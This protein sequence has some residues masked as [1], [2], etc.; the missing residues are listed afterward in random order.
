MLKE[1]SLK[2]FSFLREINI[3][4]SIMDKTAGLLQQKRK[5]VVRKVQSGALFQKVHIYI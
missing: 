2:L 1:W 4:W 5:E 3:T